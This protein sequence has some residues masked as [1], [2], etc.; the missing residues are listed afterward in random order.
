MRQDAW[1]YIHI[2]TW[3]FLPFLLRRVGAVPEWVVKITMALW[4]A[5]LAAFVACFWRL[6]SLLRQPQ[7][8]PHRRT[9]LKPNPEID[10]LT[11]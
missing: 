2:T 11:R 9:L 4:Y 3:N 8:G 1:D 10:E 7:L 6:W 5:A